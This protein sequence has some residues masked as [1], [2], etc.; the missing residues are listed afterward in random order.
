M[1][2]KM[3]KNEFIYIRRNILRI[4]VKI[5]VFISLKAYHCTHYNCYTKRRITAISLKWI[6]VRKTWFFSINYAM[7]RVYFR[8]F[9]IASTTCTYNKFC[10]WKHACAVLTLSSGNKFEDIRVLSDKLFDCVHLI[11]RQLDCVLVLTPAVHVYGP[12]L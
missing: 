1:Y 4:L 3:F 11:N 9:L 6:I 10:C 7:I 5:R 12:K 8:C 2:L